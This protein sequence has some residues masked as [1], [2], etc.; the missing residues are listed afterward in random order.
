MKFTIIV[1]LEY[2]VN[3]WVGLP[4]VF[5]ALPWSHVIMGKMCLQCTEFL[6]SYMAKSER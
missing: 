3:S 4:F 1:A 2:V 6:F 5:P